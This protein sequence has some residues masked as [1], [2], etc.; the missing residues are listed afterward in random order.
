[1]EALLK[2]EI[3][4]GKTACRVTGVSVFV[5]LTILGAFVRIPLGF[6]PVPITLQTF[7]VL[8]SGAFLGSLGSLSQIIYICLGIAGLP[9]FAGAGSGLFYLLG[10][11]GGYIAGFIL[12]SLFVSR[13]IKYSDNSLFSHFVIFLLGDLVILSS[14]VIWLKFL[15]GYPL[16]RLLFLGFIPF[17][18]GDLLKAFFAAVLFIKL[19]GR[20]KEIF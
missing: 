18:P 17:L 7:F 4:L 1:M 13:F 19:R 2:R 10:P 9:I 3:I 11:T 12:A 6:T 5:M 8:L 16:N 20:I 15:L 14:G